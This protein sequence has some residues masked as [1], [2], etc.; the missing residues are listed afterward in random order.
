MPANI[1][2]FYD[3]VTAPVGKGRATDAVYLDF[4]KDFD[5]VPQPFLPLNGR[6]M[7]LME[8]LLDG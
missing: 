4:C 1:V 2:T 7:N 8:R 3:I 6:N 5:M